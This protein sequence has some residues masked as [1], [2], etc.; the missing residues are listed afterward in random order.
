MNYCS[1]CGNSVE[2]KIPDGDNVARFV[3]PKCGQ[4]HYQNP[5]MVV[6]CIPVWQDKILL[7]KRAIEPKY[8]KWTIPAGFLE[9]NETV[10]QGAIR[11]TMEESGADVTIVRLHALYSLP[12]VN[13]VYAIFLAHM[14][15]ADFDAGDET[16][17][18]RFYETHEIPW[19]KLAFTA[20]H[21][22]LEKYIENLKTNDT[23]TY[24]G[25]LIRKYE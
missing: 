11:E 22:S 7:C 9:N 19:D 13:Q 8:G 12:Q 2:L 5:R 20:V 10:E 18:C 24:L 4:I 17:E 15:T 25:K 14:K 23:Q 1:N 21:F 16:L 6:G 3:C